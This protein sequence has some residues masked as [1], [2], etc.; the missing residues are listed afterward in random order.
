MLMSRGAVAMK[1]GKAKPSEDKA[2]QAYLNRPTV[3]LKCGC[4]VRLEIDGEWTLQ[5]ACPNDD[6]T[7]QEVEEADR[8][9]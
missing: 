3:K 7:I 9:G 1:K 5:E 2:V 6:D 4:V 8:D